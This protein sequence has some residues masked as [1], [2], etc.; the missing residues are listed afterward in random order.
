MWAPSTP[1]MRLCTWIL[2]ALGSFIQTNSLGKWSE[3]TQVRSN[4]LVFI[5]SDLAEFSKITNFLRSQDCFVVDVH[6]DNSMHLY[7]IKKLS[8]NSHHFVKIIHGLS[9]Q[10]SLKKEGKK[11][12]KLFVSDSIDKTKKMAEDQIKVNEEHYY[13]VVLR[14]LKPSLKKICL[15]SVG[16]TTLISKQSNCSPS[17]P[18]N[19]IKIA[20]TFTPYQPYIG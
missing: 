10:I 19:I 17:L 4:F 16:V 18:A 7:D 1:T 11:L 6:C 12:C 2:S 5:S 13:S 9:V 20:V 3:G 14:D 15:S 8:F